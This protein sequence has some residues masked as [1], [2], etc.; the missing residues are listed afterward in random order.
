M[1]IFK[2]ENEGIERLYIISTC[3]ENFVFG[4]LNVAAMSRLRSDVVLLDL[5]VCL[6]HTV[7]RTIIAG[8]YD[9]FCK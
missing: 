5:F 6:F 1:K 4:P 2:E 8:S 7:G 3:K 9:I